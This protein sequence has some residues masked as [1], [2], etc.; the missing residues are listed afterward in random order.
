MK[1]VKPGREQAGWAREEECTGKGNGFGGC[2]AILLVEHGDLFKTFRHALNET[3]VFIT[4][5]CPSCGVLT[6]IEGAPNQRDLPSQSEWENVR[7]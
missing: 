2:G 5:K 4:F 1:V 6:D 3:D 7:S